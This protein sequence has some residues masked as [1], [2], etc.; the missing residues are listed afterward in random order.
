MDAEEK[1]IVAVCAAVIVFTL[2]V[3]ILVIDPTLFQ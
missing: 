2:A 1:M 3:V